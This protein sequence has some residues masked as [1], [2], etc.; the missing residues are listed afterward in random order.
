M[1]GRL[2]STDFV[3]TIVIAHPGGLT[4]A[5]IRAIK[6][7]LTLNSW[8]SHGL[9]H[10]S[11]QVPSSWVLAEGKTFLFSMCT[12]SFIIIQTTNSSKTKMSRRP[13][14][15]SR[16][17]RRNPITL[18]MRSRFI[19]VLFSSI[20][21]RDESTSDSGLWCLGTAHGFAVRPNLKVA[22][23]KAGYEGALDQSVAWF[24]KTL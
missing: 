1:T 11:L 5:Q 9:T 4:Q 12:T 10:V 8:P 7:N 23:V 15:Y 24:V 3:N 19:M 18:T 21:F 14:P 17:R 22:E 16:N 13:E 6:V 2:G 20:F